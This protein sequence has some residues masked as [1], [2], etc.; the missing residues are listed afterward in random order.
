MRRTHPL[1]LFLFLF[2]LLALPLCT[3]PIN[4]FP[5]VVVYGSGDATVQVEAPLSLSY[6]IGLGYPEEDM[7]GVTDFYLNARGYLL[8]VC[9]LIGIPALVTYRFRVLKKQ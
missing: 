8:A 2:L 5:G 4:L 1:I 9:F 7:V 3:L 6:F